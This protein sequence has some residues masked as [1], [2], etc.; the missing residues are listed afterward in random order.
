MDILT[1]LQALNTCHS[2]S[3]EEGSVAERIQ[4]LA[5]PFA[6]EIS[7]DIMGNLIVRRKGDGPRIMFAAHMDSV[8]GMVTYVEESGLLRFGKVGGLHPACLPATPVRFRNGT[9]GVIAADA[10]ADPK[11]LKLEDLYVDIGAV[12]RADALSKIC[13]GDTMVY[14]TSSFQTGD[15][16]V[17]PYLD[18]RIGCV[19]LLMA[20]ERLQKSSND[21]YFVFTTQEEVGLRGARTA[22]FAVEST[23]AVAVDVTAVDDVPGT[24]HAGSSVLGK[25]AAVKVMDRSVLCHPMMVQMLTRSGRE[26]GIPVQRDII[27]AGG[28]DA[29]AIHQSRTGVYTGGI[30]VPCRYIHTPQEMVDVRDVE[31]CAALAAAF[32]GMPLEN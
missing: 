25:G 1:T 3:G 2:P 11:A 30:S 22:A 14:G 13:P 8:G 12:D 15:R 4:A 17:S 16:L 28:S 18:D 5:A 24:R 6:D 23:Y 20:M 31:A 26:H 9:R 7:T 32:A 29:G 27:Q 10:S 21:L 19:V